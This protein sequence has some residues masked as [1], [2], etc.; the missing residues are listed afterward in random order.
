MPVD[1]EKLLADALDLPRE[2]RV[3]VVERLLRSLD[4][5]EGD[6]LDDADRAR[7]HAA[8]GLSDEQFAQGKGVPAEQ[9]LD[10]LRDR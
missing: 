5:E 6:G 8:I 10:R 7:L 3:N 9:V 2:E 4:E 1:S